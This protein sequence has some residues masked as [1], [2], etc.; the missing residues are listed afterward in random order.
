LALGDLLRHNIS[1]FWFNIFA[2]QGRPGDGIIRLISAL[3]QVI[4]F[5]NVS[6]EN[7]RSLVIP[8][9]INVFISLLVLLLF[10][11]ITLRLFPKCRSFAYAGTIIYALLVNNNLYLRHILP[12]DTALLINLF[13]FYLALTRRPTNKLFSCIGFLEGVGFTV[14]P[15]YYY[16]PVIVLFTLLYR[17][18]IIPSIRKKVVL[19]LWY[20]FFALSPLVFFEIAARGISRSYIL[21]SRDLIGTITQGSYKEVFTF[22]ISY[23][24][25]VEKFI[26]IFLLFIIALYFI[27]IVYVFLVKR[28]FHLVDGIMVVSFLGY[29]SYV[30]AAYF[31]H[32]VLYGRLLHIYFPFLIWGALRFIDGMP[33]SV[34]SILIT[35][36]LLCSLVS[37]GQFYEAFLKIDY[38]RDILY[39]YGVDTNFLSGSDFVFE[40]NVL[41]KIDSSSSWDSR[42]NY[43]YKKGNYVLVNFGYFYSFSD[44][45]RPFIPGKDLMLVYK[46]NHFLSFSP[47][48]FEGFSI[49]E[50]QILEERKYEMKIYKKVL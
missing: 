12:Y 49:R 8:T 10:Y 28:Q 34:R 19:L 41:R 5:P 31:S 24:I 21:E 32:S 33:L 44:S 4:L 40:S 36:F 37:F 6:G 48:M 2:T 26:G 22:F 13:A 15:G 18:K 17:L 16:F 3:L 38:P 9:I 1:G 23:L 20:L 35:T 14:Y 39:S 47:Y 46:N 42:T 25:Y 11:R 7:Q 43:P 29:A 27:K 45:Y 50:R 30:V